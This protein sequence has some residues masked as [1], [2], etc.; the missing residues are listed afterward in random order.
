MKTVRIYIETSIRG[1]VVRDGKYAAALVFTKAD[2]ESVIRFVTGEE[3]ESTFNRLTLLAMAEAL[4]RMTQKCRVI[5]Y[6][7]NT[8]VKNMI[9]NGNPER[10]KRAEWKKAAGTEVQNKELWKLFL[11]R[12]DKQ[13]IEVRF[14]KHS[15]YKGE[16]EE[17]MERGGDDESS[18]EVSG[19]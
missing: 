17:I 4:G 3:C 11:E 12:A 6:T 14:S 7:E 9:E 5:L 13:E 15:E 2:G 19:K 10:W 18:Y 8:Y 1:P 16:L